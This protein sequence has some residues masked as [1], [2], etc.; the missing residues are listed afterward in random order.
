MHAR[1]AR[2]RGRLRH[3]I[4]GLPPYDPSSEHAVTP[5]LQSGLARMSDFE[6]PWCRRHMQVMCGPQTRLMSLF[7]RKFWEIASCTQA[8]DERGMLVPGMTGLTFGVGREPLPSVF[9]ARGCR[10]IATDQAPEG[11]TDWAKGGQHCSALEQLWLP[12]YLSADDFHERVTF[13]AV[14]MNA[15]PEDLHESADFVWSLCSMEHLGSLEHGTHFV[16]N[17]LRCLKP[18]GWAFYTTEFNVSDEVH[19]LEAPNL[20]LYRRCDIEDMVRRVEEAGGDV[21]PRDYSIGAHPY[22][23]QVAAPPYPRRKPH[24]KVSTGGFVVTCVRLII[25]RRP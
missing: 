19:T 6:Q 4:Y 3:L 17:S 13:R 1:L 10:I 16:L 25:Q 7:H 22:D 9:A 5:P 23:W 2:W 12:A 20:S 14:D 18:G 21:L 15:I 24:V 8:L 11:A